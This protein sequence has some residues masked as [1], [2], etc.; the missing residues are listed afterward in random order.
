[1]RKE[2][3]IGLD[4]LESGERERSLSELRR[5]VD[6]PEVWVAEVRKGVWKIV[7]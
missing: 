2:G 4:L 7:P 3:Y 1:M 5:S 6:E